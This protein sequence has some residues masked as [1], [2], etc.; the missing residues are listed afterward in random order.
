MDGRSADLAAFLDRQTYDPAKGKF[1]QYVY[2][3]DI[4][5]KACARVLIDSKGGTLDLADLYG[6]PWD[7]YKVVGFSTL[8]VSHPDWSPI[9]KQ[10]VKKLE[11]LITSD[12]QFDYSDKEIQ[13]CCEDGFDEAYLYVT[14][15]DVYDDINEL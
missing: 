14:V 13:I 1:A 7:D 6:F 9:S 15:Q 8:W 5:G 12:L 11:E 3:F 10:E 2:T 4:C